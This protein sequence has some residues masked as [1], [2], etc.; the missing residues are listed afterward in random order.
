[1][2]QLQRL[3]DYNGHQVRT[4]IRDGEP[5]FV[6]NDVCKI[7]E[8]DNPS[9]AVNGRIRY[10]AKGNPYHSGGLDD[11]EKDIATVNTPGGPQDLLVVNEPGLY[12]LIFKSNKPEAKN[13]KRWVTHE[14]LPSIRK[15]GSYTLPTEPPKVAQDYLAMDEDERAIAYFTERKKRK[16]LEQQLAIAAPKAEMYDVA[17]SAKNAQ[18]MSAIAKTL[19]WG[20]N[21]LFAFLREQNIL[22]HNNEPYQ[23]YIDRGYFVVRQVPIARSSGVQNK[24]QT[25]VTAKGMDYIARLLKKNGLL[26]K[27]E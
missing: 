23:E 3:F 6:A 5:W 14:V 10:D 13:F 19:G 7:L 26:A 17:M 9:L 12:S 24:P 16:Q 20:R 15:T 22:R 8:I 18:P 25:L 21:K 2:N 11:D 1:M 4:I 27:A